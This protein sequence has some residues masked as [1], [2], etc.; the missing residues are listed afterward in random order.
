MTSL[1]VGPGL[2]LKA[3]LVTEARGGVA[4]TVSV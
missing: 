3:L 4:V 2:M 1:V